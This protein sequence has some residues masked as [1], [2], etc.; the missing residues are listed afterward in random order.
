MNKLW[1]NLRKFAS[2][3]HH[4]LFLFFTLLSLFSIILDAAAAA[5]AALQ[6][7]CSSPNKRQIEKHVCTPEEF[8]CKS[9]DGECIPM[10]WVCDGNPDCSNG[11]DET[12]CSEC[13]VW[14]K[15]YFTC[16]LYLS[17]SLPVSLHW[18]ENIHG[19]EIE[20]ISKIV[21]SS[22][23]D[24]TCRSDEFTCG[25][26]RCIQVRYYTPSRKI[27]AKWNSKLL[28]PSEVAICINLINIF[29]FPFSLR[30]VRLL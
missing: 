6:S 29:Y 22:Y 13:F 20:F 18:M 9:S 5:V 12:T 27:S 30:C 19:C 26:G 17:L 16:F 7:C 3:L 28:N 11:S 24:Q 15:F 2:K 14:K 4:I 25:N 1:I 23:A 10:S 8:T 21:V